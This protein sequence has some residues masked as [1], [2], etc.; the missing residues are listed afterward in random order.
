MKYLRK[1]NCRCA[2]LIVGMLSVLFAM[3]GSAPGQ[4]ETFTYQGRLTDGGNP[5]NGNY[6]IQF[7]LFDTPSVGTG[8]QI[9]GAFNAIGVAVSG[10]IFTTNVELL[11]LTPC[12]NGSSRFLQLAVRPPG[13]STFTTLS[14]RQPITSTPYAIRSKNSATADELSV[15]C[16]NCVTSSQIA[17]VNGSAVT[18]AIPVASVPSGSNHYIR[19]GTTPQSGDFSISGTGTAFTFTAVNVNA[20]S[21]YRLDDERILSNG[22]ENSNLFVGRLAGG[23]NTT[24]LANSFFGEFAGAD[25]TFGSSNSFFGNTAG[26]FTTTGNNNSFFGARA[27]KQNTTGGSN[28]FL[29]FASGQQNTEGS[30]NSFFGSGSGANN[31]TGNS[32][33]FF[34]GAAGIVNTTGSNNTFIG[35]ASGALNITEN[36]NT[37]I[38]SQTAGAGGITNATAIG[39]K[40]KVTQSNSL[41]LGSIN[42]VNSATADTNVGIG[43]TAPVTRLHIVTNG[44]NILFGS[45]GCLS[46]NAAIGF[47]SSFTTCTNYSLLG[48]GTNTILSRP[49]NGTLSFREGNDN[50]M[51]IKPG[52]NVGIGTTTP[53][54]TLSVNGTASKLSGGSWSVFSDERLKNINGKFTRGLSA[55]MQL[56]PVRFEYK[57]DNALHLRGTGEY[58]GFRAQEVQRV[59]PEAV[60]TGA[61]GYLQVQND[62]ILWT[63]LNA[64]KE[65]QAQ[66]AELKEQLRQQQ[67]SMADL[68]T[69]LKRHG[70]RKR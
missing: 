31:T 15:A 6:D 25:N 9:G 28:A 57:R 43:T 66:I 26:R 11:C 13:G 37:F 5:A 39:F 36:N 22:G 59:V 21:E 49:V 38:G 8:T 46:G 1:K 41:I 47:G 69:Q 29:G 42:S 45:G 34:G 3:A 63:M 60:T 20:T 12:F 2:L 30:S 19:N 44:G 61:Q 10:G 55:L 24:G 62:P 35:T 65:Q 50:Q 53:T 54:D 33:A 16:V 51:V 40:A 14:P 17:S 23:D 70:R 58:V 48:D 67:A 32:N 18:G 52:G 27:G 64:V 7:M 68:K 4:T 56:Q